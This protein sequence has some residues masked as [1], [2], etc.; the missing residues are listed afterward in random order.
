M[1]Y[2]SFYTNVCKLLSSIN[3]G[4]CHRRPSVKLPLSKASCIHSK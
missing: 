1:G 2:G 4:I 3:S